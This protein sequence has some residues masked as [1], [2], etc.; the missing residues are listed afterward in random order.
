MNSDKFKQITIPFE[1][2]ELL[3]KSKLCEAEP[4][5]SVITRALKSLSESA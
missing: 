3:D 4:Y 2:K 1:L 5:Q